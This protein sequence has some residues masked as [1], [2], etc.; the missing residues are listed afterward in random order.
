MLI[1]GMRW[2]IVFIFFILIVAF[3]ALLIFYAKKDTVYVL[4]STKNNMELKS[5][6]FKHNSII[7]SKYTCDGENINPNLYMENV[8]D[9]AK[10]LVLIVDDPDAPAGTWIHWTVWGIDPAINTIKEG[11]LPE[12][13]REG[14]TSF[15][16]VGYGGPCPPEGSGA[17][18][19]SF[20]IYALDKK[21]KLPA[22]SAL[23][24]LQKEMQGDV[25][26]SAEII[27]LYSHDK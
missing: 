24:E 3:A 22:G 15:G 23:D 14:L 8:P 19:Y 2:H 27:G 21:I 12:G 26:A 9:N 6:S 7:P 13:A 18:R 11:E 10:E 1:Y 17:H 16:T 20:R 5:T 4:F 25:V